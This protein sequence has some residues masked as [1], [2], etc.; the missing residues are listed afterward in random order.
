MKHSSDARSTWWNLAHDLI[1]GLSTIHQEGL[2]HKDVKLD[3]MLHASDRFVLLDF[4]IGEVVEY[5]EFSELG[6]IGGTYGF[7]APEI[8]LD[9]DPTIKRGYEID[10]FSAGM[11]LLTVFDDEPRLDMMRAQLSTRGGA[12]TEQLTRF[13]DEPI[14][15]ENAPEET[16]PLLSAMLDF[17][18]T[19]RPNC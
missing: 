6:G 16:W 15:L 5:S 19:Q 10:I 9:Q 4:G 7:M 13:L 11:T 17:D 12:N 3:N 8:C 2:L 18:P 1:S 14:S